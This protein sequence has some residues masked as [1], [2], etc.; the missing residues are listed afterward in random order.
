MKKM[1]FSLGM[2]IVS[3]LSCVALV[4]MGFASWWIVQTPEEQYREGDFTVYT[5]EEK[6]VTFSDVAITNSTIVFGTP[7]D[8]SIT[9]WLIPSPT[10]QTQVLQTEL[11]FT[12]TVT[13]TTPNLD[14]LLDSI[15]IEFDMSSIMTNFAA[16]ITEGVLGTPVLT[17]SYALGDSTDYTDVTGITFDTTDYKTV[18]TVPAQANATMKIK[19]G[20]QFVWGYTDGKNPYTYYNAQTYTTGLASAAAADLTALAKLGTGA[21]EFKFTISTTVKGGTVAD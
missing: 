3:L 18:I 12:T 13:E 7:T 8:T 11:S 19:V 6:H 21:K 15:N 5:V 20:L 14:V 10:V 9:K 1:K 2:K 17:A 16:A 4:S